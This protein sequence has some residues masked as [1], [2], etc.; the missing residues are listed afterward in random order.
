MGTIKFTYQCDDSQLRPNEIISEIEYGASFILSEH[1]EIAIFPKILISNWIKNITR[2]DCALLLEVDDNFFNDDVIF[3]KIFTTFIYNLMDF[4]K[5]RL[6]DVDFSNS[7]V[8]NK[9]IGPKPV[10]THT[11]ILGTILKPYFQT[12]EKKQELVLSLSS[13]G[14][15]VLKEDE[16]YLVD[17]DT[18]SMHATV[19]QGLLQDRGCYVPNITP[20]VSDHELIKQLINQSGVQIVMVNFLVTGLG[21]VYRLKRAFPSLGIWG[22][23]VGYLAVENQ[24]SIQAISQL[25]IAAGV[26]FLHIGT[27]T[28]QQMLESKSALI[29]KLN[30]I[31][32][33]K[34]VFTKTHENS[35][36]DLVSHF[37]TSAVFL[38]CGSLKKDD[39]I[40]FDERKVSQWVREATRE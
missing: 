18:L 11:P 1:K 40:S 37:R 32:Q 25:A 7:F 33:C 15:Q 26:D 19:M 10:I 38:A 30:T 16:T 5:L 12:L 23:R 20:Y 35:I 2:N 34:A 28:N 27:P 9:F 6:L 8:I 4:C 3:E 24:I 29:T 13:S 39:G 14:L 31:K 21:D 17:R 22:H 36:H